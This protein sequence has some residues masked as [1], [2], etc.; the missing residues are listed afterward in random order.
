[1]NLINTITP[2]TDQ[3]NSDDFLTGPRTIRIT[4]VSAGTAEQPVN[5]SFDGDNG[6]P[7]KPAKGMRRVLVALYGP[8]SAAYLGKRVTLYNDTEVTF[9]PDKTG[10]IRISHASGIDGAQTIALTVKK[11]KR[12]PFTIQPLPDY[13]SALETLKTAAKKGTKA[14][15]SAFLALPKDIQDILRFD[16]GELKQVAATSD[17]PKNA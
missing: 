10:G 16:A 13:Q 5:V 11:G 17:K 9:G 6:R 7:W 1:M 12:K 2:R 15:T 14:L 3:Q 4:A 8:E